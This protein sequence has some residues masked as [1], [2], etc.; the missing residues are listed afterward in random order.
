MSAVYLTRI[1]LEQYR[2]FKDL[3]IRLPDEPS[4]LVVHGSNGI[5]KSS[6]FDGLEWALTDKID[7]FR[8]ADGVKRVG[9]YLCRWRDGALGTTSVTM[10]FSGENII[11]RTLSSA[12]ATKSIL[13]GNIQDIAEFL[14]DENWKR[15]ISGLS[16]YLLLTHFL[17]QS[18]MSRLTNRDP[19][20]RFD[21]LKEAAESKEIEEVAKAL[22]GRGN[23]KAS[24]AYLNRIKSLNDEITALQS[25]L[26]AEAN[27]WSGLTSSGALNDE[28]STQLAQTISR[29]LDEVAE[30]K[31][32]SPIAA[33]DQTTIGD[34]NT[35]LTE[36]RHRLR[37]LEANVVEGREILG[38]WDRA[39]QQAAAFQAAKATADGQVA[40]LVTQ[41]KD[42]LSLLEN[43]KASENAAA[44]VAKNAYDIHELLTGLKD[45]L[46]TVAS[47]R[48]RKEKADM[49]LA[50]VRAT[51]DEEATVLA[52]LERRL[53]I[54][55][56]IESE[57][58]RLDER[59]K[60][61]QTERQN[62]LQWLT[63]DARIA[64]LRISIQALEVRFPNL[65]AN[66]ERGEGGLRTSKELL[67]Q[68]N[69]ILSELRKTVSAMSNAVASVAANLS[70]D[71]CDCPVCATHFEVKGELQ[72]RAASAAE[73]LAPLV[74]AQEERVQIAAERWKAAATELEQLHSAKRELASISDDC[75]SEEQANKE[76]G[77]G[78]FNTDTIDRVTAL[79]RRDQL[80]GSA[81]DMARLR[82]RKW[83]WRNM[84]SGR[85]FDSGGEL[86]SAVRRRDQAQVQLNAAIQEQRNIARE[87]EVASDTVGQVDEIV[88]ELRG[89]DLLEALRVSESELYSAEAASKRA[90]SSRQ[91][92]EQRVSS[93][94][95]AAASAVV[96][97]QQTVAQMAA[98]TKQKTEAAE[99]WQRLNFAQS[100]EPDT[101]S[102]LTLTAIVASVRDKLSEVDDLLKQLRDGRAAKTLVG[103]HRAML[104]RLR[105]AVSG[106]PNSDR[107]QLREEAE[108]TVAEKSR[109]VSVTR[110]AKDIAQSASAEILDVLADFNTSYMQ[111]LDSLMKLI[112]RAILC[113]P[114]VGIELHVRNR[115]IEQSAT[116]EGEV[117]AAIGPIDPVLVHSEG[118]MA[119]L[120]VS[121]LCAA[122]LTYPWS[123]WRGLVLD[124]PL[125]HN[126]AIHSAAFADF[127]CN[128]VADRG[129]QVLLSTH[130]RA[131]AEFLRRKVASRNLPCAILS[132]L[133]TGQEG[134]EWNYRSADIAT[135]ESASA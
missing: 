47:A 107:L 109:L 78:V 20:E 4:V 30:T 96:R 27:L 104:E 106:A 82:Q 108:D 44:A 130:D 36:Q 62:V 86:A 59:G 37:V 85:L 83:Y 72:R 114:R 11:S 54:V 23:T 6:L 71:A 97:Q 61:A 77:V 34:L 39:S 2:S 25:L 93:F 57:I 43:A 92:I 84:L 76:L 102:L 87:L 13:G 15:S 67:D 112:N 133:G 42:T 94:D 119:A 58:G 16:S 10:N 50:A 123:K 79:R 132:L 66:L 65:D 126:D 14:R 135:P 18:T 49:T 64:E 73:R 35:R 21:I 31:Q 46:G 117:P 19:G 91:V 113:D 12:E 52:S 120:S 40:L 55:R 101:L 81:E 1:R 26:D 105:T 88:G 5:G 9:S 41:R 51:S 7:H 103:N 115:R 89:D 69:E 125:Q 99:A 29:L 45:A 111:P 8:D 100:Q 80:V 17:G 121:M 122:S 48:A 70:H 75:Y 124:D 22:H 134:V 56:R 95:V 110:S 3:D 98:T 129:Y 33:F 60:L 28:A 127:I 53:Q 131:Q 32:S 118:Q 128:L 24:R 116:K 68:Q 63:R 38:A 90:T 74:L